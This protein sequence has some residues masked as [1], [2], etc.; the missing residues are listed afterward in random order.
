MT[1]QGENSNPK[2][3]EQEVRAQQDR[4]RTQLDSLGLTAIGDLSDEDV[5]KMQLRLDVLDKWAQLN[6]AAIKGSMAHEHEDHTDKHDHKDQ[7]Y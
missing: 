3:W 6:Q 7:D 4:L 5:R 1:V 2:Q